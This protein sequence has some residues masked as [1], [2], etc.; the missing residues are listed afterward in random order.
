MRK[1]IAT[2][3]FLLFSASISAY[4]IN[5]PWRTPIVWYLNPANPYGYTPLELETMLSRAMNSWR[6]AEP[7]LDVKYGGRTTK[8]GPNCYDGQNIVY[9][10]TTRKTSLLAEAISCY[11]YR[12]DSNGT[13][14]RYRKTDVD[15]AIFKLKGNGTT[16]RF[17]V[18]GDAS[19]PSGAYYLLDVMTHEFG[20]LLALGHVTE[21]APTMYRSTGTC[22][23]KWRSLELDDIA[24]IRKAYQPE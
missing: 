21:S 23:K 16:R 9:F 8:V 17:V 11:E 18:D 1:T 3:G 4:T 2:L 15:I 13:K 10:D 22:S 19:C 12:T 6:D 14:Y 20:H 7:T 24:G 5:A